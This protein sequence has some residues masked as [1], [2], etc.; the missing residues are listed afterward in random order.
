MK[1]AALTE[2]QIIGVLRDVKRL[3]AVSHA[4]LLRFEL[5]STRCD[6]NARRLR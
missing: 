5:E 2:E 3:Q 1:R 6:A 4:L